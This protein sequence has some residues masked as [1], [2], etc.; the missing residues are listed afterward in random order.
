MKDICQFALVIYAE[1]TDCT[2]WGAIEEHAYKK[3][4]TLKKES[5]TVSGKRNTTCACYYMLW[6]C[7][8]DGSL[9]SCAS[10]GKPALIHRSNLSCAS[11][12]WEY[13]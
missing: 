7:S 4:G 13:R 10:C 8:L 2:E 5:E 1:R 9:S 12:G 6:L 3:E 11:M